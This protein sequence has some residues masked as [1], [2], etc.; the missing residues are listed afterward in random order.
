MGG[1]Q[2]L[3]PTPGGLRGEFPPAVGRGSALT[4]AACSASA[5]LT[6]SFYGTAL[7]DELL[8]PRLSSTHRDSM[9]CGVVLGGHCSVGCSSVLFG[10]LCTVGC[11]FVVVGAPLVSRSP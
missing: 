7:M 8:N 2:P 11:S 5:K 4:S 9:P 3:C 6:L 10:A 1:P